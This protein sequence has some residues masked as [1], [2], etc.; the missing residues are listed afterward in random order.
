MGRRGGK[1]RHSPASATGAL[2]SYRGVCI[3]SLILSARFVRAL[4]HAA[5]PDVTSCS[6]CR[7][8][9]ARFFD[10]FRHR[11]NVRA[12][13]GHLRRMY[14][15]L[16]TA[17]RRLTCYQCTPRYSRGL[18]VSSTSQRPSLHSPDNGAAGTHAER[19]IRSSLE[20]GRRDMQTAW[21]VRLL[22][23]CLARSLRPR[24]V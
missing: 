22:Q 3:W 13:T 7:A 15:M 19:N 8:R 18:G 2:S 21:P 17:S 14:S 16:C 1:R 24:T 5:E 6:R 10:C 4:L 20:G 11:E 23:R 9:H 12:C